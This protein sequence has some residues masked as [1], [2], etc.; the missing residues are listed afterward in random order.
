M[1]MPPTFCY[2]CTLEGWPLCITLHLGPLE[3]HLGYLRSNG[4][5]FRKQRLKAVPGSKCWDLKD[6]QGPCFKIDFFPRAWHFCFFLGVK[7]WWYCKCLQS[8]FSILMKNSTRLPL[9]CTNPFIQ[10]CFGYILCG[11]SCTYFFAGY[12]MARLGLFQILKFCFSL[13]YKFCL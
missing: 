7:L 11:L 8:H 10:R 12:N 1:W 4:S 5:E 13:Y 9:I 6:D 3:S 2:L